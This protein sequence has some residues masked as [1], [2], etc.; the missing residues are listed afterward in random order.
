MGNISAERSYNEC[1]DRDADWCAVHG[2][3][4]PHV[5]NKLVPEYWDVAKNVAVEDDIREAWAQNSHSGL[6]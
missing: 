2:R 5:D 4:R 6:D 1:P 3:H